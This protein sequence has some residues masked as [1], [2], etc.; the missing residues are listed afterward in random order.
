VK[1]LCARLSQ[2]D[3][4]EGLQENTRGTRIHHI[5]DGCRLGIAHHHDEGDFLQDRRRTGIVAQHLQQILA[6]WVD[7]VIIDD[8]REALGILAQ[9]DVG[10]AARLGFDD[11]AHARTQQDLT[12][13][14]P[15]IHDLV[16]NQNPS[17]DRR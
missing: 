15:D 12:D 3:P 6:A 4:I 1:R 5:A 8:Q 13:L 7:V 10:I 2:G 17:L 16:N 14:V 11:V 9:G